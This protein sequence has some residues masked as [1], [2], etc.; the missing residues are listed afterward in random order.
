MAR[1]G[2][3]RA[4][5]NTIRRIVIFSG[6][7]GVLVLIGAIAS[8]VR[9]TP[10]WRTNNPSDQ[11][12]VSSAPANTGGGRAT[13][14]DNSGAS[15]NGSRLGSGPAGSGTGSPGGS[16]GNVPESTPQGGERS[17]VAGSSTR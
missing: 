17:G 7:I 2:E 4:E 10:D 9:L 14:G 11:P 12:S 6:I 15:G 5:G 1:R 13:S 8:G 3:T 16:T